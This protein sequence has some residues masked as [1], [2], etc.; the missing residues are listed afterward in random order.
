MGTLPFRQ[1]PT[2]AKVGVGVA[3]FSGWLWLEQI[4]IEPTGLY[5]YMPYYSKEAACVWDLAASLT[6]IIGLWRLG[7]RREERLA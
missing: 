2:I 3:F 4:V 6:I 1:L 7:R 5:H